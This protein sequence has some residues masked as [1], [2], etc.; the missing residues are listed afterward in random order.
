MTTSVDPAA[1]AEFRA[2]LA[3]LTGARVRP[4]VELGPLPA[5][6]RLAPFSHALSAKVVAADD[7]GELASGRLILLYDPNGVA[8]WEGS[9]RIVIFLTCEVDDEISRDPLLPE[10][11]WSWL[12]DC[13]LASGATFAAL[14]GTVTATSSTR[15]G[16]IAGPHRADD[17][18]LRA[19]WTATDAD[20]GP[21]LVA[22]SE[23]LAIAS[24]LPP[25]GVASIG[26]VGPPHVRQG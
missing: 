7:D 16:D 19:S 17:L 26:R 2:A 13:L 14:G 20:L 18:E 5:P 6:M 22:F 8:A 4:E 1:P 21:H 11:A 15:F 3:G 23:L 24:G 10:V 9:L 25:E 12:A